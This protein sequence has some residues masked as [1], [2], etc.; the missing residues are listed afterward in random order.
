MSNRGVSLYD[1]DLCSPSL[2][3]QSRF[4]FFDV[5][6]VK[7]CASYDIV[8]ICSVAITYKVVIVYLDSV[9]TQCLL[10]SIQGKYVQPVVVVHGST[11]FLYILPEIPGYMQGIQSGRLPIGL[12]SFCFC[13][14]LTRGS[15]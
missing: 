9:L 15:L 1:G 4:V 6:F 13:D 8:D 2:S 10:L 14:L 5:L 7:F 3:F 11:T 12:L